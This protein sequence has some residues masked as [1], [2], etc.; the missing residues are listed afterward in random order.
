MQVIAVMSSTS[1]RIPQSVGTYLNQYWDSLTRPASTIKDIEQSRRS[2]LLATLLLVGTATILVLTINIRI[3]DKPEQVGIEYTVPILLGLVFTI[4]Y[5]LNR[6]GN[7]TAASWLS[8]ISVDVAFTFLTYNDVQEI[9]LL[10]KTPTAS[11]FHQLGLVV[12]VLLASILLDWRSTIVVSIGGWLAIHLLSRLLPAI[13]TTFFMFG[14]YYIFICIFITTFVVFRS[15]VERERR[16]QLADALRDSE[17]ANE[18]LKRS[19]SEL[20]QAKALAQESARLK[21]EFL[22]TM[23]H[24]LRTPLN[25]ITGFTGIMLGG[26]GG[27]IDED[28]EYMLERIDSN[29]KRLLTLINDVLDIAKIEA[30]RLEVVWE[31][32][33]IPNLISQWNSTI[34]PLSRNKGLSF[35]SRVEADMPPTLYGDAERLT[36]IATNLLSNAIKFTH[37]GAIELVVKRME[38]SWQIVVTDT[39]IGIPPHALHYIFEEF[40]QIDGSTRRSYGGSGLGLA[41]VRNLC[42]VMEGTVDVQ[43]E[44]N[45]GSTFTVTLPLRLSPPSS[46]SKN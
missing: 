43:S 1:P 28:A 12:G 31:P 16:Q 39:G 10:G 5:L 33:S 17:E 26:M 2:R 14:I 20:V 24:E 21:S 15:S 38:S 25:A 42:R 23:S 41:I 13:G 11:L 22:N 30:G 32:I 19:N 44:L 45:K 35:Q 27:E 36:Q 29:G 34:E 40:R 37:A 9:L 3:L 46:D 6:M 8:L 18:Q 7:Y 4:A